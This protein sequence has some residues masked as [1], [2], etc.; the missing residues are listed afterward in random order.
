[1]VLEGFL[2]DETPGSIRSTMKELVPLETLRNA[3]TVMAM[4]LKRT[5]IHRRA[6]PIHELG[7]NVKATIMEVLHGSDSDVGS[8]FE[9]HSPRSYLNVTMRAK[10]QRPPYKRQD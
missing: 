1:M 9:A 2:L 7:A 8:V 10:N 4:I 3:T 5:L 6:M